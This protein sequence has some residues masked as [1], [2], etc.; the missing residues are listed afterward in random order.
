MGSLL[1]GVVLLQNILV[2]GLSDSR[3]LMECGEYERTLSDERHRD[4]LIVCAKLFSLLMG[5]VDEKY[6]SGHIDWVDVGRKDSDFS[7]KD[8][9]C[10]LLVRRDYLLVVDG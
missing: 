1:N 4:K 6:A 3:S 2:A 10:Y 9:L 8:R 5:L 7:V